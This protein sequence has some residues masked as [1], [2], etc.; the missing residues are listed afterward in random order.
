[1]TSCLSVCL[2]FNLQTCPPGLRV[3]QVSFF[4]FL[5]FFFLSNM[6][7]I[8]H[9]GLKTINSSQFPSDYC[10]SWDAFLF[11]FLMMMIMM[12]MTLSLSSASQL[13]SLTMKLKDKLHQQRIRRSE[14]IKHTPSQ[15][16]KPHDLDLQEHTLQNKVQTH[17][18]WS[19]CKCVLIKASDFL[20][21]HRDK[22][23]QL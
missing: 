7:T 1:M 5:F 12:M 8:G 22:R 11:Y 9:H 3:R 16:I 20:V 6:L 18:R 19:N 15:R 21:Y 4:L 2:S 13:M 17:T 23:V 14:R 10:F